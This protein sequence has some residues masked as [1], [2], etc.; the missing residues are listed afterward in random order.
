MHQLLTY[1]TYSLRKKQ[2]KA[3]FYITIVLVFGFIPSLVLAQRA[4]QIKCSV[5]LDKTNLNATNIDFIDQLGTQI[6]TYI[7]EYDWNPDIQFEEYE[8]IKMTMR[9]ILLSVD[10]NNNFQANVLVSVSR[11]IYNTVSESVLI[12]YLDNQW[13]FNFTPNTAFIHDERVFNSLTS[14]LDYYALIAMGLD[15]DSFGERQGQDYFQRALNIAILGESSGSSGWA[16]ADR[17]SRRSFVRNMLNPTFDQ[18]R[19][20]MFNYHLNGLDYFTLDQEKA[21]QNVMK[22]LQ[23][24]LEARRNNSELLLFDSFFAT[25]YTEIVKVFLDAE[26]AVRLEAYNLLVELDNSHISEYDKLQ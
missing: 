3:S 19:V 15:A 4:Q 7:N 16:S 26:T 12:N 22:A 13:A 6:E 23:L 20:A 18:F 9:I 8:V 2:I 1:I 14:V 10:S 17:N 25:K 24:L 11:P 5:T 21:R